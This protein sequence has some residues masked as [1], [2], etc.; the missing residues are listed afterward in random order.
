M[1]DP[2]G[3]LADRVDCFLQTMQ[4]INL[5]DRAVQELANQVLTLHVTLLQVIDT[6]CGKFYKSV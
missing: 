1:I 4:A 5:L 3:T 2:N 6:N